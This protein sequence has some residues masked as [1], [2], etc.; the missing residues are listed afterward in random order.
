MF[1]TGFAVS[2]SVLAAAASVPWP[3][4]EQTSSERAV[5]RRRIDKRTG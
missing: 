1:A 2:G 3:V 5:A 4:V